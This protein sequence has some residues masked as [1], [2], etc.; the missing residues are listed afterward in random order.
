MYE[1]A[2]QDILEGILRNVVEQLGDQN[3]SELPCFDV[4]EAI[5]V[6]LSARHVHLSEKDA[7]ALFGGPP[8]PVRELSQPGQYLCKE[9]V[10]LI[11]PKAVID[12][13]AVLGPVRGSSQVE[14]SRTDA[15]TLGTD[16]PVRQSGDTAGTPGIILASQTGIVGLEEGLIVAARHIH[17]TPQEAKRFGVSD[18]ERVCVRLNGE[19]PVILEDVVV[20]VSDTFSLAMHIDLDEGNSAGWNANVSGRIIGKKEAGNGFCHH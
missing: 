13:V 3:S 15:R 16:T 1:K 2:V 19:R 10:R 9:R 14:I 8:T 4:F 7:L 12:N 18:N 11:G 5:P 6:E 20:R 17:M